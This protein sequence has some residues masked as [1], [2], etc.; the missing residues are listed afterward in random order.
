MAKI[1]VVLSVVTVE[2]IPGPADNPDSTAKLPQIDSSLERDPRRTD[3]LIPG[4]KLR[5][6]NPAPTS[7]HAAIGPGPLGNP[8]VDITGAPDYTLTVK[9]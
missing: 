1:I 7:A 4:H 5:R 9:N 8:P 2:G 3:N 6:Q